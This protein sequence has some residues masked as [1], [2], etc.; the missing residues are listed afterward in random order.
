MGDETMAHALDRTRDAQFVERLHAK[1]LARGL[2]WTRTEHDG[3]YQVHLGDFLIEVGDGVG[4]QPEILICDAEGKAIEILTPD[5]LSEPDDAQA[6]E[7]RQMF[8]EI[9]EAARRLALGID[10][11]LDALIDELAGGAG[12]GG[13]GPMAAGDRG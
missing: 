7:R 1:S 2:A 13:Q 6:A 3:R 4:G 8:V 12:L 10:A 11:V 5:L 9:H